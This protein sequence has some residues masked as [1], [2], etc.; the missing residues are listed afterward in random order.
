MARRDERPELPP[1][2]ELMRRPGPGSH[3]KEAII[4]GRATATLEDLPPLRGHLLFVGLQPSAASVEAGHYHQDE[5]GRRF[6]AL[7]EKATI[8]PPATDPSTAD[9]VLASAG[10]GI[11]HLLGQRAEEDADEP[12]ASDLRAGVGPLWQRI[13]VWR[14]GAVVFVD[15]RAAE[16]AAGAPVVEPWGRLEGVALSGRPCF[17]MPAPDAARED[18]A[19]GLNLLRNLA[20]LMPR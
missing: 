19:A 16:A 3:R 5:L 18:V 9:D 7:L 6:W 15:R 8:L 20:S 1:L 13:S 14:P 11:T 10:H 4:G 2:E 12:T 17:L